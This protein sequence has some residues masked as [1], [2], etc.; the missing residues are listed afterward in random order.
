MDV[1]SGLES[2]V[3]NAANEQLGTTVVSASYGIMIQTRAYTTVMI[4]AFVEKGVALGKTSSIAKL[5]Y[6][7]LFLLW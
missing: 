2:S 1:R 5:V 4:V 3:W 7:S 6:S